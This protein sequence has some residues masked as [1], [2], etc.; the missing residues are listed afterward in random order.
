MATTEPKC[1]SCDK[2]GLPLMPSRYAIAPTDMG[3]PQA[4]APL[5]VAGMAQSFGNREKPH[6]TM[7]RLPKED[8]YVSAPNELNDFSTLMSGACP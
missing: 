8:R 3:L 5:P 6:L 2:T 1:N 4:S 7:G